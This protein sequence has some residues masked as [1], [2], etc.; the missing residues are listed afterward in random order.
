MSYFVLLS[1]VN[2]AEVP[3]VEESNFYYTYYT[4]ASPVT[5]NS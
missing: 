3:N 2:T 4:F 5:V 1:L